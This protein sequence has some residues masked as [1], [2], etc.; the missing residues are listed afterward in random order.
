MTK[1]ASWILIFSIIILFNSGAQ[2]ILPRVSVV[3]FTSQ[4]TSKQDASVL[5]HLFEASLIKTGRYL[6]VE[7]S[8]RDMLLEAQAFSLS[9]CVD[10]SCAIEIGQM[11][12]AD[13]IFMG[14]LASLGSKYFLTVKLVDVAEGKG[15]G[16]E[17]IEG[18]SLEELT[19]KL[20]DLIP[21]IEGR[22]GT[23][24]I[25]TDP[26][27][28][29]V[30]Y[31][32]EEER[33]SS[34]GR[35][36]LLPGEFKIRVTG[37][38]GGE[39]F[40][41][42]SLIEIEDKVNTPLTLLMIPASQKRILDEW[43]TQL[44]E[45]T[46][47]LAHPDRLTKTNLSKADVLYQATSNA[48]FDTDGIAEEAE[49]IYRRMVNILSSEDIDRRVNQLQLFNSYYEKLYT[50]QRPQ[51]IL[52]NTFGFASMAIGAGV[53]GF[54]AYLGLLSDQSLD[55]QYFDSISMSNRNLILTAG[56]AGGVTAITGIIL[57]AIGPKPGRTRRSIEGLTFEKNSLLEGTFD[58]PAEWQ[59]TI[60]FINKRFNENAMLPADGARILETTPLL[61]WNDISEADHYF[62]QI[63]SGH[64]ILEETEIIR[65][66]GSEYQV[67]D[68]RVLLVG[69][70]VKWRVCAIGKD[71]IPGIWSNNRSFSITENQLT[72]TSNPEGAEIFIDGTLKGTTPLVIDDVNSGPHLIR[73]NHKESI[74]EILD[75]EL[76]VG[77]N[78]MHFD[79]TQPS[80]AMVKVEKGTFSMG[81]NFGAS[82]ERPAHSV[83][84]SETFYMSKT[85]VT[86][87]QY[88]RFSDETR[89][90]RAIDRGWGR[91]QQ[92]VISVGWYDAVDYCNWLSAKDGLSPCYTR[93]GNT[94][95]CDFNA[96]G[97]RL[98]T[99]AEW[100]YAASGGTA[101]RS[102][103]FSGSNNASDVAWYTQERKQ[104]VA[105]KIGNELG[106]YDMSGNA[107]EWCWDFY[108]ATYFSS[109]PSADPTG[110]DSGRTRVLKGGGPN[111]NEDNIR[112]GYR[113]YGNPTSMDK[114]YGF[115]VVARF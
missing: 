3:P 8:E 6:V 53:G 68:K 73:V 114:N 60:P 28:D 27:M 42:T 52:L 26:L 95:T 65:V 80:I 4:N 99:E 36:K 41:A 104:P 113:N 85:E 100:E 10:D 56:I 55:D 86:F 109:S 12:S 115:R 47:D 24:L 44:Q 58:N 76:E 11:L 67:P 32:N 30:V 54:A 108:S 35:F 29:A 97:Y 21:L 91:G 39:T 82:D 7:Q 75:V 2:E 18:D 50:S 46:I 45:L 69:D 101:T 61:D 84:I 64:N 79:L 93:S 94:V 51:R 14:T 63:S 92:P 5:S 103:K 87:D 66:D 49:E 38:Y 98:P 111:L 33:G 106:L 37:V 77:P 19:V 90:N 9:G 22:F 57:T 34:P 105:T 83:Q 107:W 20:G 88:D 40:E 23:L 78:Q 25:N 13:K 81:S 1:K 74:E 96:D 48:L 112:I 110:P 71:G 89:R 31:I 16:A 15:L 43:R 17:T 62:I 59:R 72:I 102:Y 70:Q